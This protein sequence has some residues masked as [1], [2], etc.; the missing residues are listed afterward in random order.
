VTRLTGIENLPVSEQATAYS[1]LATQFVEMGAIAKSSHNKLMFADMA[2][3]MKE[4]ADAIA[5]FKP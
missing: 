4:R 3:H 2:L 5:V 1:E